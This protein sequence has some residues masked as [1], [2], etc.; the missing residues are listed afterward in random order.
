VVDF[1]PFVT[2]KELVDEIK[3]QLEPFLRSVKDTQIELQEAQTKIMEALSVIKQVSQSNENLVTQI[4]LQNLKKELSTELK[5][6]LVN[7]IR[8]NYEEIAKLSKTPV[9]ITQQLQTFSINL[10]KE[11][12][13]QLKGSREEVVRNTDKRLHQLQETTIIQINND[14][15]ILNKKCSTLN[16]KV[17]EVSSGAKEEMSV[18]M[19][20]ELESM[21]ESVDRQK[22]ETREQIDYLSE[23]FGHRLV[24]NTR[25][26]DEQKRD[27]DERISLCKR[28]M[29]SEMVEKQG[30]IQEV[31][32]GLAVAMTEPERKI[33]NKNE[34]T[35]SKQA[36]SNN[37][38][39]EVINN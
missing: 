21:E 25:V 10:K 7:E 12:S 15:D 35:N 37:R 26:L 32:V 20:N 9:N 29:T 5:N 4:D 2:K 23:D 18:H 38:L 28:E 6:E 13:E 1:D 19:N 39:L 30:E 36:T 22:R 8:K 31:L 3:T 14:I 16:S 27:F 24:V 34:D 17:N 33:H 11:I